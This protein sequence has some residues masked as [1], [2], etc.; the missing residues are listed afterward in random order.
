MNSNNSTQSETSDTNIDVSPTLVTSTQ[1]ALKRTR[2][3]EEDKE[4]KQSSD[5]VDQCP[6]DKGNDGSWV[7]QEGNTESYF[8]LGVRRVRCL[9]DKCKWD[10]K[11]AGT[12]AIKAHLRNKHD[13]VEPQKKT[14]TQQEEP[15]VIRNVA[16]EL[17]LQFII[18][19]F[20]PFNI[21]RNKAFQE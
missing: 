8:K 15:K 14:E 1:R 21:V 5:E 19:S 20:L 13:R 9:V 3:R 16:N 10:T 18:S 6:N 2:V 7:W 17:L 11:F 4:N 12:A